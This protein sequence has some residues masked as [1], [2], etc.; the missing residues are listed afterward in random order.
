MTTRCGLR[1]SLTP[2]FRPQEQADVTKS[3]S[4]NPCGWPAGTAT[5]L[6]PG[7][8]TLAD[9]RA[10][11]SNQKTPET[12]STAAIARSDWECRLVKGGVGVPLA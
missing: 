1:G 3:G 2:N 11:L 9:V 6:A 4:V 7:T 12:W 10:G 8:T 5:F